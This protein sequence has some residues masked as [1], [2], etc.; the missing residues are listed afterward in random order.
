[1]AKSTSVRFLSPASDEEEF[2]PRNV[3]LWS[4]QPHFGIEIKVAAE[5]LFKRLDVELSPDT[6]IV[7]VNLQDNQMPKAIVE[8]EDHELSAKDFETALALAVETEKVAP[9]VSYAYSGD[10]KRGKAWA[11]R[12][13]YRDRCQRIQKTVKQ[14]IESS[15]GDYGDR[16]VYVSGPRERAPF[17]VFTVLTLSQHQYETHSKLLRT[18]NR[19]Y[20]VA[21]SLIDAVA[22]TFT[23]ACRDVV[24]ASFDGDGNVRFPNSDTM[25]RKAGETLMYTPFVACDEFH[26]LHGGFEA[27]NQIATLTY[28]KSI[29]IGRMFLAKN[30][31]DGLQ[32]SLTFLNPPKLRNYRAVRKLLELAGSDDALV[33][34]SHSITGIG[35]E[36][37]NYDTTD[38]DLFCVEFVGHSKWRLTHAGTTLMR[39]ERGIPLLPQGRSQ[40]VKF[41][42]TYKRLFPKASDKDVKTV[43]RIVRTAGD[44]NHGTII[45][46]HSQAQQEVERFQSQA[47][48]I[49][50]KPLSDELI[51]QTARIDGATLISADGTCFGIGLILDGLVNDKGSAERG[52][53]F[54]STVRYVLA[55]EA[56]CIGLIVSDDGMIDTVPEHRAVVSKREIKRA[57]NDLRNYLKNDD[58]DDK[59]FIEKMNW[60]WQMRFYLSKKQCK[61]INRFVA[62][63]ECKPTKKMVRHVFDKLT[64]DPDF[65][66]SFLKD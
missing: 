61:K 23:S 21:P 48:K 43:K 50:P 7:A 13:Q 20:T 8:P 44:L 15:Y 31:H 45:V 27:C 24:L 30:G 10:S 39:V 5:D 22:T 46:I 60:V 37:G 64:P 62:E 36:T 57:I 32:E 3:Y 49:E 54:N 55:C 12:E 19:N 2:E 26:G 16:R 51:R 4:F 59:Q 42:E 14:I 65:D 47:T 25:L 52:S 53:R 11:E 63:Y 29:G 6:F 33:C 17:L 58:F 18:K 41:V 28:E 38:E 1:M 56:P 35:N 34:N 9:G 66:N 40:L